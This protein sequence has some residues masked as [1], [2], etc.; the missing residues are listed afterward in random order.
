MIVPPDAQVKNP[1]PIR[2]RRKMQ[3]EI[4][5]RIPE[6]ILSIRVIEERHS[7]VPLTEWI[8]VHRMTMRIRENV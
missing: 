8:G 1:Y 7:P 6:Y 2:I 4:P 3:K 5:K